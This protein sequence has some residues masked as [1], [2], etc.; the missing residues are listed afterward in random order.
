MRV[1]DRGSDHAT[2]MGLRDVQPEGAIVVAFEPDDVAQT[3]IVQPA[4]YRRACAA[5][6]THRRL[7]LGELVFVAAEVPDP[8]RRERDPGDRV[9]EPLAGELDGEPALVTRAQA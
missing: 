4:R 1:H 3:G 5:Q 2:E 7:E 6:L 9:R 8:F